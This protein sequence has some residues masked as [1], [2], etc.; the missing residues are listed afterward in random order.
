MKAPNPG[1]GP[2]AGLGAVA[3]GHPVTASAAA[4]ILAEGGNAFDA[5][6]AA[7]FAACVAEPVLAS[8]GGGGFLLAHPAAGAPSVYDF[9]VQTPRSRRE[10]S[11]VDFHPVHADFGT[12]TQEF[13]I[14]LGA[15]ATPGS[16]AGMEAIHGDLASLPMARLVEPAA[17]SAREGV[18][19][20]ALQ[21]RIFEI[22]KPIYAASSEARSIYAGIKEGGLLV[23][24]DLAD[25]LEQVAR[26][27]AG[28][29]YRGDFAEAVTRLAR[30]AGGHLS[31]ADLSRYRVVRRKPL[32]LRHAGATVITNPPPSS[33]GLLI[34]FSL[35]L[36]GAMTT[37]GLAFGSAEHLIALAETMAATNQARVDVLA[38]TGKH[39]ALDPAL[40][41]RYRRE[42]LGS[43]RFNRGTTHISVVDGAG[44]AAAMTLSNGEGC[45]AVIPGTGVM[46]NNML[47]EEDIN[48]DG[49]GNWPPDRRLTSMM[50][51]T[52]VETATRRRL[53]LGS[54]GSNRIRTAILQVISNLLDFGD[55]VEAAVSRPR[56]HLEGDLLSIESG[57][58]SDAVR[59]LKAG[60][61][62][63]H[64]WPGQSLFFGGVHV[65]EQA[66]GRFWAA[67]DPRRGGVGRVVAGTGDGTVP[68]S[69][70][71]R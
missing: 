34:G 64:E 37:A 21:A 47:G 16:L 40:V 54:G 49:F 20:E 17:R 48:P 23:Q 29:F 62:S 28:R 61:A 6:I 10:A 71:G 50:A 22:V 30:E 63:I 31:M 19:T 41:E 27:G 56:L 58:E 33:G 46:L 12:A 55:D 42:I 65:A 68:G 39:A 13:H 8:L 66:D 32:S 1:A 18:R 11:A 38:A 14:G 51:P 26:D 5:V 36:L 25:T 59:A 53:A 45:G 69:G 15:A 24:S 44:N 7:Q 57:F 52:L 9:F 2:G 4:E 35:Q 60:S 3:C 70:I 43:P 67:G